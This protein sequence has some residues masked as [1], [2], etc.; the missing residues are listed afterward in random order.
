MR[1][2]RYQG[3]GRVEIVEE[4]TP[5]CPPGGLLVRTEAC[6]LCSGELMDWYMD[7]KIPHVLGHE[8]AGMVVESQD[9]RFPLGSRVFPHHHAAALSGPY[10]ET[11]HSP[12]WKATKLTPGGMAEFFAVPKENL[13]DAHL[14]D[15]L[16][17]QDAALAE[18]LGCV[19]KSLASDYQTPTLVIGL[20][21]M[22]LVHLLLLGEGSQGVDFNPDRVAHASAQGLDART[23]AEGGFPR[24]VVCPGSQ[25]AFDAA[26]RHIEPGGEIVLFAPL[27]PEEDLRIPQSA[28]FQDLRVRHAYSCALPETLEAMRLLRESR[29]RAEQCVTRF[30]T[31]D[32]LPSAYLD[33][34]AGR[35]LKPMVLFG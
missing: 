21:F 17:P 14:A 9:P 10:A 27:P 3:A 15:D 34:K 13:D 26:L 35:V 8:V 22:G 30:L 20:G 2:A 32:D 5:A 12:Q 11:V 18:P 25:A 19:V 33:M 23:Q 29:V 1:L 16:A 24:V 31:L 6:G 7:R 4:P 28:Y